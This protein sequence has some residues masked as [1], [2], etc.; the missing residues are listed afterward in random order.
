MLGAV[1]MRSYPKIM[2]LLQQM[3]FSQKPTKTP[4]KVEE[5]LLLVFHMRLVFIEREL[6][7]F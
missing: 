7:V 4:R 6:Q 1:G 5:V 3:R 2:A